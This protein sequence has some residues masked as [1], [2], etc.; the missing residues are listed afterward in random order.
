VVRLVVSRDQ[1]HRALLVLQGLFAEA[2]RRGFEVRAVEKV[3]CDAKA[4]VAI[5]VREHAYPVEI[6]EQTDRVPLTAAEIDQWHREN[7]RRHRFSWEKS[8]PPTHRSVANGTLR[9]S[10]PSQGGGARSNWS[11]GPRGALPEKL[12]SFF[13]ALERRADEDDRRVAERARREEER[14]REEAERLE[15]ELHARI[16]KTREERL[17][18]EIDAW[19]LANDVRAYVGAL[20]SRLDKLDEAD[21]TRIAEWCSWAEAWAERSDPTL[22]ASHV[23]GLDDERD[24]LYPPPRAW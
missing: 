24:R 11:E 9:L 2:E 17:A 15:R 8:D 7:E 10:L 14:L 12:V 13:P 21:R 3:K 18:G 4:G 19:R 16:E 22:N 23:R 5:V 1:V 6:T 20:R